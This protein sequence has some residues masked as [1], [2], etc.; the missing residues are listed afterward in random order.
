MWRLCTRQYKHFTV[1]KLSFIL[2]PKFHKLLKTE[3]AFIIWLY[4]ITTHMKKFH[5]NEEN[6]SATLAQKKDFG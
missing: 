4:D 1:A 6:V 5:V 2:L 3:I